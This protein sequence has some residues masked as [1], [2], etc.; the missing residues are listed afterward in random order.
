MAWVGT[1]LERLP[2]GSLKSSP[3]YVFAALM[4]PAGAVLGYNLTRPD[5][6]RPDV[7]GSRVEAPSVAVAVTT[8][9]DG[10]RGPSFELRL[11]GIRF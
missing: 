9:P 5:E 7:L 11:I 10:T 8:E 2:P 6:P 1:L 3:F 4:P